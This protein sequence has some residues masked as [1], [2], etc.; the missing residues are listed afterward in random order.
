MTR[1]ARGDEAAFE[2]AYDLMAGP[3]YGIVLRVLRDPAQSEEVAQEVLLEVWR[4]A[5]RFD[6]GRG[7]AKSWI[8]T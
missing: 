4:T 3:V 6:P 1:V 5:T 7:A 2:Q 8:L